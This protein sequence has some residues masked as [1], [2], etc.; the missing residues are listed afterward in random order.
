MGKRESAWAGS[1]RWLKCSHFEGVVFGFSSGAAPFYLAKAPIDG[2]ASMNDLS[3]IYQ[4]IGALKP[5][6]RNAR[7]HSAKQITQ[8]TASIKEFGFTNPILVDAANMVMAGHGRLSAAKRLGFS[9]VPTLQLSHLT[10]EQIRTYVIADNQLALN[11][12]WDSEILSLELGELLELDP[13]FELTVTGFDWPQI[14]FLINADF[15]GDDE[16]DPLDEAPDPN[17]NAVT[18]EG[19][20]WAIGDHR[21]LCGDATRA[22]N[23]AALLGGARAQMVFCDPPYN[24]P[25][26]G[27]VSGLGQAQHREFAMASGEMSRDQFTD[28]LTNVFRLLAES[29]VNGAL[30]YQCMD[31]RHLD[32]IATAGRAAYSELKNLCVWTKTNA[33]M[34]SLYRSQHELVF[35]F[36]SG[37]TPHINNVELGRHGRYRTN[38][39]SYPGA[40]TFSAT[41]NDDL[42]M[43]PTVKPVAMV[44]DAILDGS[45]PKGII[46]DAFAGSGTTLVA[47]QKTRRRGYGIEL[48]PT[49][50]DVILKRLATVANLEAVHVESGLTFD[51]IAQERGIIKEDI[52]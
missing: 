24:V 25:I 32:E 7:T 20:L 2:A 40:N 4:A 33:G 5:N 38:V 13:E 3:I 11:A 42:A 1:S 44:A 45:R 29:S 41:R 47:A 6:P 15:R 52:K 51:A 30:H 17:K 46:L 43:H 36:K 28:F 39:W 22:E 27:H 9:N 14:D 50:C 49:Y 34:G 18:L 26:E 21:L 16:P 12:G 8:I 31:W 23:Y 37:N 10:R 48:D 35:V 19:D